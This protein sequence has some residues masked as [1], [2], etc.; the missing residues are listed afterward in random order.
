MLRQLVRT[1]LLVGSAL[2]LTGCLG[3]RL[4]LIPAEVDV[5]VTGTHDT[6][7]D[8]LTGRPMMITNADG[9]KSESPEILRQRSELVKEFRSRDALVV[10]SDS[11]VEKP[12]QVTFAYQLSDP[13]KVTKQITVPITQTYHRPTRQGKRTVMMLHTQ[14]V[15]H[16]QETV[17]RTHYKASLNI[18][19]R[20]PAADKDA[21]LYTRKAVIEGTC[22][23]KAVLLQPLVKAVLQDFSGESGTGGRLKLPMQKC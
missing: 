10:P 1:V 12:L 16:R 15:G 9:A 17:V 23:N 22:N 7:A 21:P 20:D 8:I 3:T 19:I 11:K 18:V 6:S 14:T 5:L 4:G 2:A 13:F